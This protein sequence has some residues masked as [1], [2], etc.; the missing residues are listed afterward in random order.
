[1][2]LK[3]INYFLGTGDIGVSIHGKQVYLDNFNRLGKVTTEEVMVK[4]DQGF[5]LVK[6]EKLKLRR[7]SENS[8]LLEGSVKIIEYR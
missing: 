5:I 8:M 7:L 2:L 3:K 6:G 4:H 1:M